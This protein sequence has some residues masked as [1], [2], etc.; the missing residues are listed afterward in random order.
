M[1]IITM[2][3]ETRNNWLLSWAIQP[4]TYIG[5]ISFLA[6]FLNANMTWDPSIMFF[7][8]FVPL[9]G[10]SFL[11]EVVST[12]KLKG[13]RRG[14]SSLSIKYLQMLGVEYAGA[15]CFAML[16]FA[17][18]TTVTLWLAIEVLLIV[19]ACRAGLELYH[20]LATPRIKRIKLELRGKLLA[21][22]GLTVLVFFYGIYVLF[23]TGQHLIP[24]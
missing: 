11:I 10:A 21:M 22:V 18:H 12:S 1:E 17:Q 5:F 23:G 6:W 8:Y 20:K 15:G 3:S 13:L 16:T 14:F 7:Y 9:F 2:E 24:T 4:I 19:M